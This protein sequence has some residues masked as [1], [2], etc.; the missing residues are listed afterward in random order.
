MGVESSQ[1]R[2]DLQD[3]GADRASERRSYGL[4]GKVT[5]YHPNT[6][7]KTEGG[8]CNCSRHKGGKI[9]VWERHTVDVDVLQGNK[10]Q[11][12]CA[13]PC[14]VYSQGVIDKGFVKN[15]RVWIQFINGD[16]SMP[17]ATAY[18]R[19]PDQLE[20]FWN[21]LKIR[22]AGFFDDLLPGGGLM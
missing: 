10:I 18:Y 16:P 22:V 1:I 12:L 19:E 20:L 17:I 6:G 7:T 11:H 15:D 5:D 2:K 9:E 13:V 4:I 14:F 8:N 3:E 21:N